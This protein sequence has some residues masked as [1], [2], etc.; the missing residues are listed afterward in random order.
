[1][2]IT[3]IAGNLSTIERRNTTKLLTTRF[4][5]NSN[6]TPKNRVECCYYLAIY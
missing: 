6:Y 2:W 3:G 4:G 5:I 1:M